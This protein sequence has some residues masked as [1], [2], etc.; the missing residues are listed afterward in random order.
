MEGTTVFDVLS[1]R[2]RKPPDTMNRNSVLICM[3]ECGLA[4][5]VLSSKAAEPAASNPATLAATSQGSVGIVPGLEEPL[6]LTVAGE[7]KIMVRPEV[8]RVRLGSQAQASTAAAAQAAVSTTVSRILTALERVG[9]AE[10]NIQTASL[11]LEPVYA[12]PESDQASQ[13]PQ[14]VG[15]RAS[16][17]L[18]VDVHELQRAGDVID[19]AFQAGAN[20]LN[21]IDFGLVN[22]SP[23]RTQALR[24]AAQDAMA[25][26]QT[27]AQALDVQLVG[28]RSA[29]VDSVY[30]PITGAVANLA[31][32]S[33]GVS[34]PVE[35]GQLEVRAAVSVVFDVQD[36]HSVE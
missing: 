33:A 36:N 23:Y 10:T 2:E 12:P 13:P 6:T 5:A 28:L 21:G 17:T 32:Q 30:I 20:E 22:E 19:A 7:G 3:I 18:Q 29:R 1:V 15:Y 26:A 27:L 16:N 25:K 11:N 31:S 8:A 4:A 24:L 35:P 9:I 14:L 34:T